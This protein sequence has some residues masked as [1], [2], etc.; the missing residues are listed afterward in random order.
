MANTDKPGEEEGPGRKAEYK[1]H[2]KTKCHKQG[3]VGLCEK[4]GREKEQEVGSSAVLIPRKSG[5]RPVHAP[6]LI[7]RPRFPDAH[8]PLVTLQ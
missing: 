7:Q 5:S 4:D 3:V 8:L 6:C 2:P 1:T